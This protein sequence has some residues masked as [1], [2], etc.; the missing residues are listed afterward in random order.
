LSFVLSFVLFSSFV[1][2]RTILKILKSFCAC[3]HN[4]EK[5]FKFVKRLQI[6][7]LALVKIS[8]Y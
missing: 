1:P 7:K 8:D 2:A 5:R 6:S 3:P 4:S